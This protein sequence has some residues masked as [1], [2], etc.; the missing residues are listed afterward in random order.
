MKSKCWTKIQLYSGVAQKKELR[1]SLQ[2][3]EWDGVSLLNI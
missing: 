2:L 1:N 3:G